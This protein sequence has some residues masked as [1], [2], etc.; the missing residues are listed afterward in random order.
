MDSYQSSL[1][2]THG[3]LKKYLTKTVC[4]NHLIKQKKIKNIIDYISIDTE[5]NEFKIIKKKERI[6]ITC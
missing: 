1:N 3:Y 5:G 6:F 4:L 2:K